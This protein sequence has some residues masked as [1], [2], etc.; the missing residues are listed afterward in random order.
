MEKRELLEKWRHLIEPVTSKGLT[1]C[2][3]AE[4]LNSDCLVFEGRNSVIVA[5]YS[6]IQNTKTCSIWVASGE[7]EEVKEMLRRVFVDAADRGCE[8]VVYFGRR[9][10]VKTMGFQEEGVIGVKK[11]E[12]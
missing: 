2:T 5:K 6:D 10:W 11:L 9:G 3:W 12:V 1:A 8:Q 4:V 7:L